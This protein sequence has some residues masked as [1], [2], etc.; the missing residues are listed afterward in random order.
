M[1][2]KDGETVGW[3]VSIVVDAET[4]GRFVGVEDGKAVGCDPHQPLLSPLQHP[5]YMPCTF[6]GFL[7]QD[8]LSAPVLLT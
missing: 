5:Q 7:T 1:G 3:S 6:V 4:E 8:V 2:D